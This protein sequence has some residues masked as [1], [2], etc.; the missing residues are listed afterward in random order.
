[1]LDELAKRPAF[2]D[3]EKEI[4]LSLDRSIASN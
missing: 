3:V 4:R 2:F 1:L